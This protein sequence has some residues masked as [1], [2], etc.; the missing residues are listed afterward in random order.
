[1][2][3][4]R[5]M[6]LLSLVPVLSGVVVLAP[7]V[8]ERGLPSVVAVESLADVVGANGAANVP[9][10]LAALELLQ[11]RGLRQQEQFVERTHVDV[12]HAGQMHAHAKVTEK[13]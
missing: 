1:M 2:I 4:C 7:S 11:V 5:V 3:T 10:Q 8:A 9:F 6:P 13:K 12:L